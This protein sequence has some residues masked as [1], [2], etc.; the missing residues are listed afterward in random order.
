MGE[1]DT[2]INRE[3]NLTVHTVTGQPTYESIIQ[4]LSLAYAQSPTKSIL[5]DASQA[6]LSH[7]DGESWRRIMKKAKTFAPLRQEGKTAVVVG[8]NVDFG[9]GRMLEAFA[10]I[11][12]TEFEFKVFRSIETAT[13]WLDSG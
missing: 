11:E 6:E 9:M 5:W 4:A 12:E 7:L 1:V 13:Q 2:Q 8:R 10:D 3:N